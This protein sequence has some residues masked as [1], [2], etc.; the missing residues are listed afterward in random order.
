VIF[1]RYAWTCCLSYVI[2]K[3][4][5]RV[6]RCRSRPRYVKD[7]TDPHPFGS[8]YAPTQTVDVETDTG[9]T[10]IINANLVAFLWRKRVSE[11]VDLDNQQSWMYLSAKTTCPA[12]LERRKRW[13]ISGRGVA[14]GMEARRTSIRPCLPSRNASCQDQDARGCSVSSVNL[15][16]PGPLVVG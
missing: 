5:G 15:E 11:R 6:S 12:E 1:A 4:G 13:V 8:F 2:K 14:I 16:N 9:F 3:Y 10:R 7:D